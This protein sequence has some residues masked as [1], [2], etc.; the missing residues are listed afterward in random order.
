MKRE[1]LKVY[2]VNDQEPSVFPRVKTKTVEV[3]NRKNRVASLSFIFGKKRIAVINL[4][5][6]RYF[7][8]DN[9]CSPAE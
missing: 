6:V 2:W 7:E 5:N 3:T 9:S 8:F 1:D 4:D